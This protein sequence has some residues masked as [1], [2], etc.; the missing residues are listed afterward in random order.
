MPPNQTNNIIRFLTFRTIFITLQIAHLVAIIHYLHG[1]YPIWQWSMLI[2]PSALSLLYAIRLIWISFSGTWVAQYRPISEQRKAQ[3]D[4]EGTMFLTNPDTGG[5]LDALY[6]RIRG[7]D[8]KSTISKV[9][10][11]SI[12]IQ[13]P[14]PFLIYVDRRNIGRLV[15]R[16]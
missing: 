15:Q 13:K 7:Q 12:S 6:Q 10:S 5:I 3:G 2:L 4:E 16:S 8:M 1:I 11:C 9:R 14:S